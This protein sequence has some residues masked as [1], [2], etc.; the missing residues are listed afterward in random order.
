[1][2]LFPWHRECS[3]DGRMADARPDQGI[4]Q[5]AVPASAEEH[6]RSR[7][8]AMFIFCLVMA[9][10]SAL[11]L[12]S[13]HPRFDNHHDWQNLGAVIGFTL[14]SLEQWLSL[15]RKET[16]KENR[17]I[18]LLYSVLLGPTIVIFLGFVVYYMVLALEWVS[19]HL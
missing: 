5:G 12:L 11:A 3:P 4:E 2:R 1:M 18:R 13:E 19:H 16:K 17:A 15:H 9:V 10:V 6:P 7:S 14:L 8:W